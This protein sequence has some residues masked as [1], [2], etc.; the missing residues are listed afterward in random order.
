ME[1]TEAEK[2]KTFLRLFISGSSGTGKTFSAL[3]I[4]KGISGKTSGKIGVIEFIKK[5]NISL[6][7]DH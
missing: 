4:A 6:Y 3:K 5:V 7:F 1:F 2:V